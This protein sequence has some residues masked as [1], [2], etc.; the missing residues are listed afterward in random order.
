MISKELSHAKREVLNAFK[1]IIYDTYVKIETEFKNLLKQN[2]EFDAG[3]YDYQVYCTGCDFPMYCDV[4]KIYLSED[5]NT[6][7]VE[8]KDRDNEDDV[9][10]VPITD[11]EPIGRYGEH[12]CNLYGLAIDYFTSK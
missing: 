4:E 8:L 2:K 10:D 12:I 1:G 5:G 3:G 11:L 6:I 7:Y 9:F